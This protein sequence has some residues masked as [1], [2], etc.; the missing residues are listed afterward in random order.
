ME[1]VYLDILLD[2]SVSVFIFGDWDYFRSYN[3]LL[4]YISSSCIE[5]QL[6]EITDTTIEQRLDI[7]RDVL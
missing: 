7:M 1:H 3:N 6:H 5:C 2:G 4:S